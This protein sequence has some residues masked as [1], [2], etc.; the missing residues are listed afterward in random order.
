MF[1]TISKEKY[2]LNQVTKLIESRNGAAIDEQELNEFI[3]QW[4][5]DYE[6]EKRME[7]G[8]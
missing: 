3:K 7:L 8:N 5:F 4:S 6:M 1:K 2:L